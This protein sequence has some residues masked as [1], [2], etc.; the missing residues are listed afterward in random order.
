MQDI[1][2]FFAR[3]AEL[4]ND[5]Q[6]AEACEAVLFP[7][8]VYLGEDILFVSELMNLAD[9]MTTYRSNLIDAGLTTTTVEILNQSPLRNNGVKVQTRW[10]SGGENGTVPQ[11]A[12]ITFYCR[13][14]EDGWKVALI[15]ITPPPSNTFRATKAH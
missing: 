5:G 8:T 10:C 4:V 3:H 6:M 11:S 13:H 12:E 9:Y 1:A 7:T 14:Q 2:A 15:E